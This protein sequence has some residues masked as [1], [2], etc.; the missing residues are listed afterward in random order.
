MSFTVSNVK[1]SV[2]VG[3][4]SVGNHF[5]AGANFIAKFSQ[6]PFGVEVPSEGIQ[7]TWMFEETLSTFWDTRTM[8]EDTISITYAGTG[9]F[10][11]GLSWY[12]G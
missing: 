10:C 9:N 5:S 3:L 6:S 2:L 4:G 8:D 7:V 12:T 11:C 1:L